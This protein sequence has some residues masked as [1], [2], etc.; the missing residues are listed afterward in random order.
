MTSGMAAGL[1]AALAGW[2]RS[3]AAR[4]VANADALRR[5]VV[6]HFSREAWQDMELEQYAL[7]TDRSEDSYCYWLEFR[8]QALGSIRGGSAH[9]HLIFRQRSDGR[10]SY[11][12]G[13]A[14]EQEAWRAVRGAFVQAFELAESGSFADIDSAAPLGVPPSVPSRSTSTSPTSSADLLH[15]ASLALRQCPR[16]QAGRQRPS[17]SQSQSRRLGAGQP[18]VPRLGGPRGNRVPLRV[19]RSAPG[20]AGRQDRPRRAGPALGRLPEGWLHLRGLERGRRPPAVCREGL[21]AAFRG[22]LQLQSHRRG[23]PGAEGKRAPD[24]HGAGAWGRRRREQR[25]LGDR[26]HRN[27]RRARLPVASSTAV[28]PTRPRNTGS[29][30]PLAIPSR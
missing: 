7:G 18:G 24:S 14:D 23:Q 19:G 16:R 27:R 3:R 26:R 13:F 17:G 6:E 25:H 22:A 30:S 5:Q 21:P 2:D 9:K 12:Q 1:D 29:K 8:A 11:P 20:A 4:A 10:W 28:S 15:V